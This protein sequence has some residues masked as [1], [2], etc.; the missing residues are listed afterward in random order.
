MNQSIIDNVVSKEAF[1][2]VQKL[3]SML[4]SVGTKMS[5]MGVK[6]LKSNSSDEIISAL[7]RIE[8]LEKK[9]AA[10]TD[11]RIQKELNLDRQIKE[12]KVS[13]DALTRSER[14]QIKAT[15]ETVGSYQNLVSSYNIAKK[16]ML[17]MAAA[18]D[19]TSAK[20]Q[21]A[22]LRVQEL[23]AQ[24][25]SLNA[26]TRGTVQA[27]QNEVGAYAQLV[28]AYNLARKEMLDMAAAGDLTSK[29]FLDAKA[30]AT[31]LGTD[32]FKL[33]ASTMQVGSGMNNAYNSTFQMTQVMR[34]LPNFAMG[35]RIG[36]MSLSNNLPM[37]Y[38]GFAQLAK[39]IDNVTGK[40]KDA[41]IS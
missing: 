41:G 18:G 1:D 22:R 12:R 2:Q 9:I 15:N 28:Q 16:E 31:K 10:I 38:D 34:E 5:S 14:E 24:I 35:A 39:Q 17:D 4:E 40:Q 13:L 29:K 7:K 6:S 26:S 25:K 21:E 19:T 20:Y 27:K 30:N 33:N 8:E 37:L 11:Q 32:L 23:D 3:E 36:F